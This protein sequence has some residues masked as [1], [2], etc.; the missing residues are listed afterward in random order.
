VSIESR[1]VPLA[2]AVPADLLADELAG[3]P[4]QALLL[5]RGPI[6]VMLASGDRIPR[7]LDEIG[8]CREEAFRAV[9]EGTGNDVD[10]DDFDQWY[11]H[12]FLWDREAG[13]VEGAY[14]MGRVDAILRDLGVEGLYT[15]TLFDYAPGMWE[16]LPPTL[17]LGRAF[18]RSGSPQ[19]HVALPLLWRGIAAVLCRC[20]RYRMLTGP[21][22]IDA[23]YSRRAVLTM[24]G[25]LKTHAYAADLS[26]AVTPRT[27]VQVDTPGAEVWLSEG[28]L[29]P[30]MMALDA[31][32][33]SLEGRGVPVLLRQYSR[34]SAEVLGFNVD[35]DFSDVVDALVLVDLQRVDG[36][37]L[38]RFMGHA[39]MLA[40]RST[41]SAFPISDEHDTAALF[42]CG[43]V[44]A[45][46]VERQP[47]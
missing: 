16:S 9:G 23:A 28:G 17:E 43:C 24:L 26:G 14:R 27:P 12:V 18:F 44:A 21:L 8:R 30:D 31:H 13:R 11:H 20:P 39:A 4:R 3:L 19:Q 42:P 37:R 6:D 10:I 47:G 38:S 7:L 41:L 45:A 25:H 2:A 35:H 15:S 1:S 33:K 29:L 34:L 46:L 32:I 5:T 22:S 36:A 40:Y